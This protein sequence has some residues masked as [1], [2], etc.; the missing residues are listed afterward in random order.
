MLNGRYPR[1]AALSAALLL[2][3]AF[4]VHAAHSHDDGLQASLHATCVVCQLHAPCAAP[5]PVA[6]SE[7]PTPT[8][9]LSISDR[10]HAIPPARVDVD[11]S[12]APPALIA[13]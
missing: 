9:H 1:L 13:S 8:C 2:V 3:V 4:V 10:D 11:F 12:R 6:V 5:A 7:E